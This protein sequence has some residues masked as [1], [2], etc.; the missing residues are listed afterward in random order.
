MFGS[1]DP[2]A[3]ECVPFDLFQLDTD[4][5]EY[6]RIDGAE[7][8]LIEAAR[9]NDPPSGTFYD[10]NY[11]TPTERLP[12]LGVWEH[13]NNA[14]DRQYSRNLGSGNGIE[15]VFVEG[16]ASAATPSLRGRSPVS[17]SCALSELP[18]GTVALSLSSPARL[19]LTICDARGRQ[20]GALPYASFVAGTHK[21][22]LASAW[23]EN[24]PAPAG[25]YVVGVHTAQRDAP[26]RVAHCI[27]DLV[28]R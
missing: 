4:P 24:T 27:V 25:T 16:A 20:V 15:L 17:A 26:S 13:W 21:I 14:D 3:I 12:S 19:R 22:S 2:V 11:P 6:P 8:Y 18:G 10:P 7:D 28:H 23:A 1:Q 5:H 9:A